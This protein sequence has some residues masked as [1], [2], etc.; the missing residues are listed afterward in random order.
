MAARTPRRSFAT[1]FVVTLAAAPAA[2]YVQSGP[3][4]SSPPPVQATQPEQGPPPAVV[5]NP[6][7]PTSPADTAQP[8]QPAQIAVTTWTIFKS[9]DGCS[10]AVKTECPK[11]VMCNPPRPRQFPCPQR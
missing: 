2:C 11:G 8:A 6:P 9:A 10:A 3:P 5:S 7:R 1:P 4:A